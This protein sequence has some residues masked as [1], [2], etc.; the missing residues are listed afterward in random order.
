[1]FKYLSDVAPKVIALSDRFP[2]AVPLF[3]FSSGLASFFLVERKQ[4]LAQVIAVMILASW[5]WLLMEKSVSHWVKQWFGFRLPKPLFTYAAQL[6]HQESLFFIIPFFFITTT[7]DSGQAIYS[8]LLLIAAII[9]LIDPIYFRWLAPRRIL[10]FTFHGLT[11]FAVLLTALPL[12]FY[13][14]TA[15][16]Y[17]WSLGIALLVAVSGVVAETGFSWW[18]KLLSVFVLG[19]ALGLAGLFVRPWVPPATLWLTQVA[20]TQA[21]DES[22]EPENN[23]KTLSEADIH[24]GLYAFTSIHAPRGLRERIYHIWQLN[25]KEV[26]RVALDINGGREAGYRAWTHKMNF[27][28]QA[29]GRWQ[30]RVVTETNQ[31]IGIL[32]FNVVAGPVTEQTGSSA[33]TETSDVPVSPD[34]AIKAPL[35]NLVKDAG[36]E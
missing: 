20:I 19:G 34:A 12:I 16:A 29:V 7:W 8:G 2:W 10:Y 9:S 13:L 31:L 14:P 30:I 4:E 21:I 6:V 28:D 3:G 18:Q 24:N 22:R 15:Q 35:M 27:P 17:F 23:L 33:A 26:D 32:R 11:L 25:G 5:C 36:T 1:M